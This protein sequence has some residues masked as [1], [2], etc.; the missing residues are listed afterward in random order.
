MRA[1]SSLPKPCLVA[2]SNPA[3]AALVAIMSAP[4]DSPVSII[5][6]KSLTALEMLKVVGPGSP[7]SNMVTI[8]GARPLSAALAPLVSANKSSRRLGS[9]PTLRAMAKA[10]P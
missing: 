8:M 10:S 7:P 6:R 1:P 2:S 5:V 4:L 3:S 9:Q